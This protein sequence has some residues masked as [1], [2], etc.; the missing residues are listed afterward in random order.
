[1]IDWTHWHNE[2][3][4][5]GGLVLL[6]WLYALACGPLRSRFPTA[7]DTTGSWVTPVCFYGSLILFYLA[8]GS[9]LD[10]AGERFL[11][12]AHMVQHLILTHLVAILFIKGLPAWL[13]DGLLSN[14]WIEKPLRLLLH[15]IITG[16]VY[17]LT[18]SVWHVP[19]LY[20]WALQDRWVHIGEHVSFFATAV[21]MWWPAF[22]PSNR[23][24]Q[25]S[26]AAQMLYLIGVTIIGTPLFAYLA[27]SSSVLYPTYEFAPRIIPNF[28]AAQDQLLGAAIMKL[29][30]M[31]VTFL[32]L[33]RCFYNWYISSE[34]S[35]A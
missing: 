3:H 12:S 4:L 8:V 5:I 11:F 29:G 13:I 10:Q 26:S 14:P 24:P 20:D 16:L 25:I 31:G 34:K 1:M 27:F 2:P 21:L 17:T 6:A 15:P 28:S 19:T 33:C 30:T 23:F 7:H 18:L 32:V 9:P 35:K 22:S